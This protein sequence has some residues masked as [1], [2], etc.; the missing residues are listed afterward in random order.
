MGIPILENVYFPN[1]AQVTFCRRIVDELKSFATGCLVLRDDFNTALNPLQDTSDGK[2]SLPYKKLRKIKTLLISLTLVDTWHAAN[3]TG[4]AFTYFSALHNKF[5]C[6]D[7]IFITQ[8]DL[9]PLP[10]AKIGI[11][12][13]SDHAPIF[14][15]LHKSNRR[16]GTTNWRTRHYSRTHQL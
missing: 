10:T 15:T 6:M 3:P 1:V 8:R 7:Y 12:T 2:S 4:R 11:K 5:T 13:F 9:H 14:L 16:Y